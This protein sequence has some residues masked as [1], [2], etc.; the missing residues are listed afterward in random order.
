MAVWA[1]IPVAFFQP[2]NFGTCNYEVAADFNGDGN[3]DVAC[4]GNTL[5]IWLGDGHGQ[6][7]EKTSL[8][9]V[10]TPIVAGDFN[11]DGRADL[12]VSD[13]DQVLLLPG[14]GDGTFGPPRSILVMQSNMLAAGDLNGDGKLDLVVSSVPPS[15]PA[16]PVEALLGNGDGTFQLPMATGVSASLN[17]VVADFDNDGIPDVASIAVGIDNSAP[18]LEVGL[19]NGDGTFQ[20]PISSPC[21]GCGT[22]VIVADVNHDGKLDVI[23]AGG[24]GLAVLL[25]NG[26]GTFQTASSYSIYKPSTIAAADLNGDGNL[27]VVVTRGYFRYSGGGVFIL[28]GNSDGSF[29]P[30]VP[31]NNSGSSAIC[32][33][34]NGD[35]KPD[36]AMVASGGLAVYL[37][38]GDGT[39]QAPLLT[40]A[41]I[42]YSLLAADFNGDGTLDIVSNPQSDANGSILL[43]NGDGTF[44]AQSTP[45]VISPYGTVFS[46]GDFNGDGKPDLVSLGGNAVWLLLNTTP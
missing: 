15:S 13:R 2:F 24:N 22:A 29:G 5:S 45:Y 28:Y 14:R 10:A 40:I 21:P 35:G 1:Q 32:A 41:P 11:G 33:D 4:A 17:V 18:T 43:G 26:D 25:G 16:G 42:G 8:A 6:F 27:D 7:R 39:F 30:P 9:Y 12:V 20:A 44:T 38:N 3:L 19:G 23:T 31:L 36:I 46:A 34:F 37:G